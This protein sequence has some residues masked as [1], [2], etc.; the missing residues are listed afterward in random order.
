[1]LTVF[2]H[3]ADTFYCDDNTSCLYIDNILTN[4]FKTDI[5]IFFFYKLH[6][7]KFYEQIYCCWGFFSQEITPLIERNNLH[8]SSAPPEVILD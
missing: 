7:T 5:H 2:L 6:N 1:M 8:E 4:C 3:C